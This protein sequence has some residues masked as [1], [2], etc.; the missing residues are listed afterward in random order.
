M[1]G[2][3]RRAAAF[4]GVRLGREAEDGSA[5]VGGVAGVSNLGGLGPI[6]DLLAVILSDSLPTAD[7]G[8]RNILNL[9]SGRAFT[10]GTFG[11]AATTA[12]WTVEVELDNVTR[13]P[14]DPCFTAFIVLGR[15]LRGNRGEL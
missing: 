13:H 2:V 6:L 10:R 3:L 11:L 9:Y 14:V 4:L 5:L 8:G 1:L 15:T 12:A 7:L